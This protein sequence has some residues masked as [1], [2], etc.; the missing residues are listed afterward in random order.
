MFIPRQESFA[1]GNCKAEVEPLKHGTYRNHCPQ[2]LYSKHV[3]KDGPGD[4]KAEC[5]GLMK[6]VSLEDHPKKNWVI[7]HACTKC[8][9]VIRNKAAPDDDITGWQLAVGS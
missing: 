6:P 1:C 3:D 4:R 2:C 7:T 8:D 5:Q 9:K